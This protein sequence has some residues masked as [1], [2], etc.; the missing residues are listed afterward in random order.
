MHILA[1]DTEKTMIN[2]KNQDILK[3]FKWNME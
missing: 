2:W 1:V 3:A